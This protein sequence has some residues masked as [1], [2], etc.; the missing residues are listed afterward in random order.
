LRDDVDERTGDSRDNAD[1]A[2]NIAAVAFAEKVGDGELA[3]FA[4]VGRQEQR[5]QAV[6]AGPAHDERQP[7]EASEE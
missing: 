3:E 4:Q 2:D 6:T 1:R 7:V 5:D